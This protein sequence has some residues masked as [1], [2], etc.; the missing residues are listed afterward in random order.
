MSREQVSSLDETDK[1]GEAPGEW[2][3]SMHGARKLADAFEKIAEANV[4]YMNLPYGEA[5]AYLWI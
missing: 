3:C 2:F 1:I 5:G 4:F